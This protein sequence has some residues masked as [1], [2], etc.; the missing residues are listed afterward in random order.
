MGKYRLGDRS[1][2]NL[3]GVHPIMV[4]VVKL[5]IDITDQDFTVI[6]GVRRVERQ[7][8][9]VATGKSKTMNSRHL[10]QA[11]GYGHAVDLAPYVDGAI[12]WTDTSRFRRIAKAVFSAAEQVSVRVRWGNDWDGDGIEVGPDPDESFADW[13]HFELRR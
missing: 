8:M 4:R 9:L 10:I 7:K 6:E 2:D 1:L 12:L 11:D 3:I 5:A 13:P